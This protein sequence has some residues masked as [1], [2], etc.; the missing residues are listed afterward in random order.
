MKGGVLTRMAPPPVR[1]VGGARGLS[2]YRLFT[3]PCDKPGLAAA[4]VVHFCQP[5]GEYR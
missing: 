1:A 5:R 2:V 3:M 4:N